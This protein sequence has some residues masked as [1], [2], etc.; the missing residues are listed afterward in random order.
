[1]RK[2]FASGP[3]PGS[4]VVDS[5]VLEELAGLDLPDR[6]LLRRAQHIMTQFG[7]QPNASIPQACGDW[8]QSKAAYRFFDNEAVAAAALLAPHS[9]A[10][11]RRM[12]NCPVVLAVQDSTRLDYS[13]H[14]Q[15]EGLGPIA[16]NA[17]QTVGFWL[18]TTLALTPEGEPLG[19][20]AAHTWARDPALF[21]SSRD[22]QKRNRQP[23]A[24]KESHRWLESLMQC[25]QLSGQCPRTQIVNVAD[26]EGDIYELLAQALQG[27][28]GVHVLV[29]I[30]HNRQVQASEKKLWP[31]LSQ[32]P[33]QGWLEVQIPRQTGRPGR[34]ARMSLRFLAVTLQ[35][36][37]L[38]E[39]RPPLRLWAVEA[40]EKKPV[41]GGKPIL[42]RL[43][44]TLPVTTAAEAAEKVQWYAQRWQIEVMH[45]VLKSGCQI[46]QRQLQSVERLRRAL[47]LDLIVAWRVMHL[48]RG[49]RKSP[50]A[51][52]ESWLEAAEW[53]VLWHYF[54]P[55]SQADPPSGHLQQAVRWIGQLGGFLARKSDG[56]PGPIV[57][58]R[59]LQRLH[60]LTHM[61][62]TL[63]NCG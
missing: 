60:D 17:D 26:R 23:L 22:A 47:M 5:W 57:L 37:C 18:H 16:H 41:P 6:R 32:Q 21:G 8:G 56:E 1:M 58:W 48:S 4:L 36:P 31:L 35:A 38:K 33:E 25:Q 62:N 24:Q 63:K 44:T 59:G 7:R 3:D 27:P 11:L 15:T 13:A 55:H 10:T 20:L 29:R 46:Q 14:P 53:K 28:A 19:V 45:K 49:A 39:D 54:N 2:S 12:Q 40:R 50:R 43:L 51:G 9:Q 34:R 42:W 30:Q 52:L 61:W